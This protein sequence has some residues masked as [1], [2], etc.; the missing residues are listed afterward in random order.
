M[1]TRSQKRK[2]VAE[3]VSREFETRTVEN[4]QSKNLIAGPSKSPRVQPEILEEVKTSLRKELMSDLA[5]MLAE[6]QKEMMKLIVPMAKKLS[7]H[8]N[9]QDSDSETENTSVA[10]TS[11][12]LKI[13]T[14]TSKTTPIDS[15]NNAA[16]KKFKKNIRIQPFQFL[17][18]AFH[19]KRRL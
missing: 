14:A 7:A 9:F 13:Y 2:A 12:P 4:N 10:R 17:F 5:K 6:N 8:Q 16:P 15:R 19:R 11:T 18:G 1:T 3:L